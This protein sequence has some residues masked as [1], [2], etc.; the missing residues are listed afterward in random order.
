MEVQQLQGTPDML[1]GTVLPELEP[2][3]KHTLL[4][5]FVVTSMLGGV[6]SVRAQARVRFIAVEKD[7]Q[8]EVLD[9]G[10]VG[11]PVVLL[12]GNGQTAHSFEEFA[13]LLASSYHVYG[14]TRRGFGA[15][16]AP[17]TGYLADR[18]AD[19]VLAVIDS[20]RLPAP[21][22]AGHS[23]AGQELSSIGSRHPE[24]VAGLVYLDAGYAY[25][26]Y[27]ST[28]GNFEIEFNELMRHR[29]QLHAAGSK[30]Q[31]AEVDRLLMQLLQ[32]DLPSLE[33]S[34]R[35]MR[36]ELPAYAS[37][38]PRPLMPPPH[39]GI[40]QAMDDGTQP[41]TSIRAPVLAIYAIDADVP[42]ELRADTV[43]AQRWLIQQS[44]PATAF[45]RGVPTARVVMMPHANHFIFNSNATDV[46]REM[47]AFIARLPAR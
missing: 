39:T 1:S 31:F 25:A 30:G 32:S 24:R 3:M 28:H 16:S 42:P 47:R 5:A 19:D 23:R 35:T 14:I 34:L 26:F 43:V 45:A 9:W 8:L 4:A 20:L 44:T 46:L 7:V 22:L 27:D 18:L 15:S 38:P 10:G 12:A 11:R 13:P 41:Y 40:A 36:T 17:T 33:R 21:V 2:R 29:E 37:G 6:S